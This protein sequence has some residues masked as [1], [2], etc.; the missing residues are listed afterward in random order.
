MRARTVLVGLL[1]FL[2]GCNNPDDPTIAAYQVYFVAFGGDTTPER[3]RTYECAVS[4]H[5]TVPLPLEPNG[6]VGVNLLITRSLSDQS[7]DHRE[8]TSAD[9]VVSQAELAYDGLGENSLSFSLTAGPYSLAPPPGARIPSSAEYGGDWTCGPEV[10]LAQDST[11]MFY[12]YD[13]N[14]QI[15]G[16]WRISENL[17]FE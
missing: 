4:G 12:G 1:S 13:P 2:A 9:T 11:L 16:V 17:P 14:I 6:T 8:L 3:A 15:P 10:P 5:F 7:G